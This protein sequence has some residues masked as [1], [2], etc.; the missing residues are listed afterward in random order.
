M[1]SPSLRRTVGALACLLLG[2]TALAAAPTAAST[3]P[4]DR[5]VYSR[6][7]LDG[8]GA[9]AITAA[10]D[11]THQRVVSTT[12]PL[13]DFNRST[14]SH[15]GTRLLHSN[16]VV[17]DPT[18]GDLVAFRPGIS[19]PSGSHFRVLRLPRLPTDMFCS[20]WTP[21]DRRILCDIGTERQGLF[22]IR[23]DDGGGR[24]R[25]TTNP[26]GSQDLAVGFSPDGHR[27]AFLRF[28]PGTGPDAGTQDRVALL[29]ARADG[30]H[31]HRITG[32]AVLQAHELAWADWSPDGR[33]LV[34]STQWGRLVLVAADG[35]GLTRIRL[36]PS[37]PDDFAATPTFSPDGT[38]LLFSL[39][40][41][42]PADLYRAHL[43]GSGVQAVTHSPENDLNP[44]WTTMSH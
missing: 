8:S 42:A 15:D 4:H 21:N 1:H 35:S 43:D 19:S 27:L 33:R 17:L 18:T 16:V 2:T 7:A 25:L 22:S 44:D 39:F 5:I 20:A 38:E 36:R 6:T 10:P 40:R 14:W 31:A 32:Y 28:R 29:V 24:V 13:E 11:G 23:A 3:G 34:S 26:W 9:T 30:S 37:R 41:Q 12:V